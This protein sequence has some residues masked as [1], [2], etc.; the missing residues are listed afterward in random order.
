MKKPTPQNFILLKRKDSFIVVKK[1][2]I[3]RVRFT[4]NNKKTCE[5]I[6]NILNGTMQF[7]G[8]FK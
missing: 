6:K 8:Y 5:R 4:D 7:N 1:D 2:N 3:E